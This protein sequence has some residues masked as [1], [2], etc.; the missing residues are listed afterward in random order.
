VEGK[1][2]KAIYNIFPVY[3]WTDS[4]EPRENLLGY[5]GFSAEIRTEHPPP[6]YKSQAV[7]TWANF[8][9]FF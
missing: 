5:V 2:Q 8:L 7:A 3:V 1:D 6:G 4:E 9:G